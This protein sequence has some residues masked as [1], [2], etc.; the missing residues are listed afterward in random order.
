[1]KLAPVLLTLLLFT[2]IQ[3]HAQ[4]SA[5]TC[6]IKI[7]LL[8]CSPGEELYSTFGHSALRVK[9]DYYGSDVIYNYGTFEFNDEFYMKFVRGKL[10]YFLSVEKY[11]EFVGSYQWEKRGIIEQELQLTCAEKQALVS[12]LGLNMRKENRYYKYDFLFDNCTTRL[13]DIISKHT[14]NRV[15]F[16]NIL[17]EEVPTFR[18][19]L[20]TYLN[21]GGQHWSKL[22]ID[23]LLGSKLDK[24]VTNEQAM[25]LP[26]ILMKGFDNAYTSG[27]P[28][29]KSKQ[30]I[31]SAAP[32]EPATTWFRP[33]LLFTALFV[34]IGL[35]SF[36]KN[37]RI[38][39]A[40]RI[41]DVV[42][43]MLLGLLGVLLLFMWFGTDHIV[44]SNNYNL[45]W[46]L[47]THLPVA[48]ILH[49][50][51]K[52]L[53]QY[54]IVTLIIALLLAVCWLFLPQQ[55]NTTVLPILGIIAIRSG[56]RIQLLKAKN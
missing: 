24:K 11:D 12:A 51:K 53:Q 43:F 9:D 13:R 17:P 23:I 30:T 29:V 37:R 25:F 36:N 56:R 50:Q 52:W 44:C 45:L 41:F 4:Q 3:L 5:D 8:T 19:L 49:K 35:L 14:S 47:P 2:N 28:L 34:L 32:I 18:N 7:S 16:K 20:Y 15:L 26:E 10:N 42:F 38:A 1:M 46:A 31:L 55:L 54:F 27:H 39:R 21:A 40:M 48:F 33:E 22:G 6:G